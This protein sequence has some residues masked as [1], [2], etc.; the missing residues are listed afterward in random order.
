[1]VSGGGS[2]ILTTF[3]GSGGTQIVSSG[4]VAIS[5]RTDS[6]SDLT[7]I[8]SSG[9]LAIATLLTLVFLPAL[10]VIWHRVKR[11]QPDSTQKIDLPQTAIAQPLT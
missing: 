3:R 6:F 1:M 5:A 10:Y 2:A 7:Q 9:G 11:P 8:V 4:G